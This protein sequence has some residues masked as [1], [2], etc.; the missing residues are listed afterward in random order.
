MG[1]CAILEALPPQVP[2][3]GSVKEGIQGVVHRGEVTR[4]DVQEF[5]M[6]G[7]TLEEEGDALF[8]DDQI[9][10]RRTTAIPFSTLTL[11]WRKSILLPLTAM[12][13]SMPLLASTIVGWPLDVSQPFEL[14]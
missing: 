12:G 9:S 4:I 11:A 10:T 8:L 13:G 2:D 6:V 1:R 3:G 7:L 5:G 14:G